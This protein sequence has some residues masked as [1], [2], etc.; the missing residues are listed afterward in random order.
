MIR[1]WSIAA[2]YILLVLYG[3]AV[4]L[5]FWKGYLQ[6][7]PNLTLTVLFNFLWLTQSNDQR[8]SF[9]YSMV[10]IWVSYSFKLRFF[11]LSF[12]PSW[13]KSKHSPKAYLDYNRI[14]FYFSKKKRKNVKINFIALMT[15][16]CCLNNIGMLIS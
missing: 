4:A 5:T 2:T 8:E 3:A 10:Y 1:H 15:S 16:F 14:L 7:F 12:W 6:F 13:R 9:C 11:L